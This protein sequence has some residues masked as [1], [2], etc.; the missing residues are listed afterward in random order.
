[1]G[2]NKIVVEKWLQENGFSLFGKVDS[3]E[4]IKYFYL[5]EYGINLLIDYNTGIFEMSWIIPHSTFS[6]ESGEMAPVWNLNHLDKM[7]KRFRK[8]VRAHGKQ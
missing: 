1:M 8:E 5:D 4:N 2:V 3:E 6:I 7:C